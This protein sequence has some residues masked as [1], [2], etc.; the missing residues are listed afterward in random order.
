MR[1][2]LPLPYVTVE[3]CPTWTIGPVRGSGKFESE[4]VGKNA[5]TRYVPEPWVHRAVASFNPASL[6]LTDVVQPPTVLA[7]SAGDAVPAA[8]AVMASAAP[9]HQDG[10][11]QPF[12]LYSIVG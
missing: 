3:G 10:L 4:K 6:I 11:S 9:G 1:N 5:A 8:V 2:P 7:A 12:H